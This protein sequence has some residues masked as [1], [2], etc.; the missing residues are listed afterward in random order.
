[1]ITKYKYD[2]FGWMTQK[3]IKISGLVEKVIGFSYDRQG[4]LSRIVY[5]SGT[6]VDNKYNNRGLLKTISTV[7]GGDEI[8]YKD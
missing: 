2:R 7:L 4:K 8:P 5:P 6:V 1:M 3:R